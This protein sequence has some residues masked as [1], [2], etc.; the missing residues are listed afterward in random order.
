MK[1]LWNHINWRL[2]PLRALATDFSG[3]LSQAWWWLYSRGLTLESFRTMIF[4]C[5]SMKKW[6]SLF[7]IYQKNRPRF[8]PNKKAVTKINFPFFISLLNPDKKQVR[9]QQLSPWSESFL[10]R[11]LLKKLLWRSCWGIPYWS[12]RGYQLGYHRPVVSNY[13]SATM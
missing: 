13:L 6:L 11:N 4:P 2:R 9:S 12:F 8:I 3:K 1:R 10:S 5:A 7:F